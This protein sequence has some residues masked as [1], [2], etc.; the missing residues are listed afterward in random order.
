MP[1]A[2]IADRRSDRTL[3]T[4]LARTAPAVMVTLIVGWFVTLFVHAQQSP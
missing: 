4:L 1:R 2:H 3:R